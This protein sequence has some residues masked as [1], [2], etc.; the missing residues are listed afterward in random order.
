LL[1]CVFPDSLSA[2]HILLLGVIMKRFL[3]LI[4]AVLLFAI[5]VILGLKNQQLINVNYLIAENEVRLATLLAIIF[6]AG[7]IAATLFAG[8]FYLKLKMKNRQLRR[9]NNKQ[10]KELNQLRAI[11]A[12]EK[13]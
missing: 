9:L 5:A 6:M 10:R 3:T 13:D 11:T 7:F 12:S 2:I 8:L 1:V 4:T